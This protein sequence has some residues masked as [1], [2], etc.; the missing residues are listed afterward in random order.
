MCYHPVCT[1]QDKYI[2]N[3]QTYSDSPH[4]YIYQAEV[5]IHRY[6]KN[7]TTKNQ[8]ERLELWVNSQNDTLSRTSYFPLLIIS[9]EVVLSWMI[10]FTS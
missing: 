4:S 10:L 7:T 5:G 3:F 6:L 1:H 8:Q 9:L 2:Y